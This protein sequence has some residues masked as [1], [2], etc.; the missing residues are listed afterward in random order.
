[1]ICYGQQGMTYLFFW[2][3]NMHPPAVNVHVKAQAGNQL[4]RTAVDDRRQK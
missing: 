1:M 2:P 3:R 4:S